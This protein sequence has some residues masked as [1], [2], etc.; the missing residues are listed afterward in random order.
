MYFRSMEVEEAKRQFVQ[1]WGNL[2]TQ[3]GINRSMAQ[4]HALLLA[5]AEPISTEDI[6]EKLQISRGNANMNVRELI[7]WNLIYRESIP[8]ERKEF[9]R[10]EKDIWVVAKRIMQERKR[11][12]IE[13]LKLQLANLKE[14][15]SS[16]SKEAAEFKNTI[17]SIDQLVDQMDSLSA[18][19]VKADEKLFLR[20]ILKIFK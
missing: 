6:M 18:F 13:P 11:R 3:W 5:S 1:I 12:E 20:S 15:D 8:G 10:A 7:T 17:Q 4:V 14:F 9:F 16:E 19:L 2:G